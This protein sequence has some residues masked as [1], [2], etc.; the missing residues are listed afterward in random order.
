MS[1]A[2][3][4]IHRNALV[5][6]RTWRGSLFFSFVQPAMFLLAMGLG[7][8]AL[9]DGSG[10]GARVLPAGVPFLE[11]LAPGLLAAACMQT[12]AFDS[13]YPILRK[14]TWVRTYDAITATPVG[15]GGI[16]AGELAWVALRLTT[17][18]TAF[19]V[20]LVAFGITDV[21]AV[22]R[23]VPAGVLTGL[24][25]S[26]PVMAYAATLR[27][28]GNFNAVFRFGITPLFL[29]SGVFVPVSLL[30]APLSA[31]ASV[32]PLF[33]GVALVRGLALQTIDGA[34]VAGHVAYLAALAAAGAWMALGTFRRRLH[35]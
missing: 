8:G 30:P 18:A 22:W 19:A 2:L 17:V 12:A 9:V 1:G 34:A 25:F 16:V 24:A 33:H 7:V 29:F 23:V 20:V 32:T 10:Q 27:T 6:R 13:A 31:I 15:I 3:R 35:P 28:S 14:I 11:F 5:Y 21:W 26:A 4:I